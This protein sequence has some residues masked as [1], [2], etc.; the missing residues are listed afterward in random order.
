MV[1]MV[2]WPFWI[3]PDSQPI[4]YECTVCHRRFTVAP[5]SEASEQRRGM[6]KLRRLLKIG[7]KV[8]DPLCWLRFPLHKLILQARLHKPSPI[9]AIC[10]ECQ[11]H[12][13][14]GV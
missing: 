6:E 14:P 8:F 10:D 1:I 3:D 5:E 13:K 4:Q 12:I 9:P 2:N 7:R 11:K